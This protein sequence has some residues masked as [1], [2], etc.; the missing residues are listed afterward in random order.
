MTPFTIHAYK[1]PAGVPWNCQALSGID[2]RWGDDNTWTPAAMRYKCGYCHRGN[3]AILRITDRWTGWEFRRTCHV[4]H[5][6]VVVA[7]PQMHLWASDAKP[8]IYSTHQR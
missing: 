8:G 2:V 4:C 7:Q 1:T 3:V 6:E 5:A